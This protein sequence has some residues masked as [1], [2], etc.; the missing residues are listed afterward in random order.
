MEQTNMTRLQQQSGYQS[1]LLRL[2]CDGSSSCWRA[3]LVDTS[4]GQTLRFADLERVF[5]FLREQVG[6]EQV[7]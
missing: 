3:A 5:D 6:V 7:L 4:T 1:Y 2:W